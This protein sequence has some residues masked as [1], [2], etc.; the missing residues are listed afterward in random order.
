EFGE[1]VRIAFI[2]YEYLHT[3]GIGVYSRRLVADLRAGGHEVLVF[4]SAACKE[5][6]AGVLDVAGTKEVPVSDVPLTA[7]AT[8]WAR[9][10]QILRKEE[11]RNG[12]F[13][14]IPSNA[15]ADAFLTKEGWP[16]PRVVTV[17]HL[18]WSVIRSGGLRVLLTPTSLRAEYGPLLALEGRSIHRA[19][20]IIA[21]SDSTKRDLQAA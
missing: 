5:L 2:C 13:D 20:H 7:M 17:Y 21:I 3:G 1:S 4:C 14:I 10:P 16:A 19:D 12:R 8:F 11:E 18:G 6:H 15:V 9:L